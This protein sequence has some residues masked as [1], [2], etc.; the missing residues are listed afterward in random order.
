M[1]QIIINHCGKISNRDAIEAT[2][3]FMSDNCKAKDY[4]PEVNLELSNG[5]K[6]A[7]RELTHKDVKDSPCSSVFNLYALKKD[8]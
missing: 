7:I 2:G 3:I 4:K 6:V 5:V 8:T 1:T